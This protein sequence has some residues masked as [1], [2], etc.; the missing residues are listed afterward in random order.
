MKDKTIIYT[1]IICICL[2][3]YGIFSFSFAMDSLFPQET[4]TSGQSVEE[5]ITL[6]GNKIEIYNI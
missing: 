6:A 3:I 5:I 2:T 4:A 1:T